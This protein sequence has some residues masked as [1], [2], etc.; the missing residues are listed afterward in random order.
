MKIPAFQFYPGDALRDSSLRACSLEARGL[1]YEMLWIMHD[2][3]PRGYLKVSNKDILPELPRIIGIKEKKLKKLLFELENAGVFSKNNEGIIYSRRMIRDEEI[4]IKRA[5]GGSKSLMNQ[6]V[7]RPSQ[8]NKDILKG[9]PQGYPEGLTSVP[10]PALASASA[11]EES[12][13]LPNETNKLKKVNISKSIKTDVKK[14]APASER[15]FEL[16]DFIDP[17][18]WDDF[19]A[20][21]V[22]IKKPMGNIAVTR[23]INL[24]TTFHNQGEDIHA[25]MD[26][27]IINGWAGLFSLKNQKGR[28]YVK[29]E[30]AAE[31][32]ANN[33]WRDCKAGL[34]VNGK[35]EWPKFDEAELAE[36]NA[37]ETAHQVD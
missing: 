17:K 1:W 37:E 8:K 36:A 15:N 13:I 32:R 30:S 33:H 6:R 25:V 31:E 20:H 7:P 16:P 12:S 3:T 18:D 29:R 24:L 14:N 5:E 4:R 28:P 11:M 35:F 23:A 19:I 2:A 26:Q 21:R 9:H 22:Q 10:S 27:S 34:T